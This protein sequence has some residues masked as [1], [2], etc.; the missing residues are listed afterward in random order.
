MR[1]VSPSLHNFHVSFC[2]H[3]GSLAL[4]S[5]FSSKLSTRSRA[6]CRIFASKPF[7]FRQ[8]RRISGASGSLDGTTVHKVGH[9]SGLEHTKRNIETCGPASIVVELERTVYTV[10]YVFSYAKI[11]MKILSAYRPMLC[12]EINV[13]TRRVIKQYNGWTYRRCGFLSACIYCKI[14]KYAHLRCAKISVQD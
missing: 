2:V 8:S 7:L 4:S 10:S 5:T 6:S 1:A 14:S 11:D 13:C 3:I 12:M 9:S